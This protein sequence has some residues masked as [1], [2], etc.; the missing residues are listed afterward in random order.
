MPPGDVRISLPQ[1][2]QGFRASAESIPVLLAHGTRIRLSNS[3]VKLV[4]TT[5]FPISL[6]TD[7]SQ[8]CRTPYLYLGL[9]KIYIRLT[10]TY[11]NLWRRCA[12]SGP[13]RLLSEACDQRLGGVRISVARSQPCGTSSPI[14]HHR[15]LYPSE[16]WRF[17]VYRYAQFSNI[18]TFG[19]IWSFA[20]ARATAKARGQRKTAYD[21]MIDP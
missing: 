20:T 17:W 2:G 7:G 3:P 6:T 19:G 9:Y 12:A 18:H 15:R 1:P 5:W 10:L 11:E 16:F 8:P 14:S 4:L 13:G 21:S